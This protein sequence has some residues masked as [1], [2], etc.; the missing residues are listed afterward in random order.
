[1]RTRNLTQNLLACLTASAILATFAAAQGAD[2]KPAKGARAPADSAPGAQVHVPNRPSTSLFQGEQG[3]QKTEIYFDPATQV[4]TVKMLVQDPNGYFI[5]NIRRDNFAV[6]ENGTR[7]HNAT[8]E[9][10]HAPVSLAVLMEWGGRYQALN[11]A[12]ADEVPRAAHQVLDELGR[13]DKVAIFRYGDRV[14]RLADFSS[15]HEA[16]DG[17][18]TGLNRPEFSELNFYDALTSTLGYMKPVNGRKAV[19]LISSGIDTFSKAKYEDV[20]STARDCGTPIYV[21]NLGPKLRESVEYSSN[22]GPYARLDWKRAEHELQEIAKASGGRL[23]SPG[24]IFDLSGVYDDIMENLRV[25]YVITYKSNDDRDLSATRTVRVEL[26][27][28]RTGGP[29]EIVDA[30]GKP[31]RSKIFVEDSYIPRSASVASVN[32]T[33]KAQQE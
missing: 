15:G 6:Y 17:L 31:V 18:F 21:V 32:T 29:L 9:I 23:Y 4:V 20:L 22:E 30:N 2:V 19:I 11:K 12:L 25:R 27:D 5:P 14:D 7:Q 10:E 16:L 1:M 8:V 28:S 33:S 3:K 24:S 26:V 13:Q